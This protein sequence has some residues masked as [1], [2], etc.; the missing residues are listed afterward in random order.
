MEAEFSRQ[1][2]FDTIRDLL[3]SDLDRIFDLEC[4]LDEES[5]SVF[6]YAS[7]LFLDGTEARVNMPEHWPEGIHVEYDPRYF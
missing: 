2:A 5:D 4:D 6:W 3:P 1:E 7:I